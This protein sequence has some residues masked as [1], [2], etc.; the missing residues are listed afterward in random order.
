MD[1][2][3]RSDEKAR[4]KDGEIVAKLKYTHTASNKDVEKQED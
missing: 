3:I 2:V 1:N 4:N